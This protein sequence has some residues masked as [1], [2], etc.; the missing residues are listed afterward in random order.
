MHLLRKAA[1]LVWFRC[2]WC[3]V[4][5]GLLG[6]LV[7]SVVRRSERFPKMEGWSEEGNALKLIWLSPYIETGRCA[8]CQRQNMGHVRA[9]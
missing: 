7:N 8:L 2:P 4:L 1:S 5:V 6:G 9:Q 3:C